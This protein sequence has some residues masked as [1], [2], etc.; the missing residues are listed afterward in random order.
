MTVRAEKPEGASPAMPAAPRPHGAP[1]LTVIVPVFDESD[2][3]EGVVGGIIEE[4]DR[5]GPA[6]DILILNDGSNDWSTELEL[7]LA[8]LGPVRL[9]NHYPNQGKGAMLN[10]AFPLL[11]AELAVVIDA[12]GEYAAADIPAVLGP[13]LAGQA[14]WVMGSRYGFGRRR[15]RQYLLAYGVNRVVNTW[16]YLLSGLSF[17]DL[18][19][20]LYGF[21]VELVSNLCLR[22]R[23]FSYTAELIWKL[24][25]NRGLRWAERP[26]SYRF[27]SYAQGKKIRWWETGTILL[28][29]LRY[30]FWR[31]AELSPRSS[32]P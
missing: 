10:S 19:T 13:L 9:K 31:G 7:R 8:A 21:R 32:R 24:L 5:L 16:F 12:D 26:V 27:R 23:R 17:Q 2:V 6:Y 18:L 28:A 4:L 22:E 14:D 11:R 25:A 29:L 20:G 15:P 30:R 3:I 1:R